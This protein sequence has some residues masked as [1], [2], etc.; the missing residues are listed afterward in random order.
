MVERMTRA[1]RASLEVIDK[2]AATGAHPAPLLFVHGGCHSAWYWDEGFLDYFAD[3]GFRAVALSLRGH[4]GSSSGK[5]LHRC[6][7][8]DFVDDVGTV[9]DTMDASVVLVGHS[10]GGFIVQ[11][12]L[13]NRQSTAAVLMAS[14]PPSGARGVSVRVIRRHPLVALRSN[15]SLRPEVVFKPP[16]TRESLFS[17][18]TPQEIVDACAER[19]ESES[20]RAMWFDSMFRLPNPLAVTTPMLVLGGAD[21]GTITN[22]DVRATARAYQ[23][24]AELFPGMG[25]NMMLEPGWPAVAGRI[26]SWLGER[27]L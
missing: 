7:M 17:R 10:V 2:G 3:R 25:H 12:Y 13:E 15:L 21:D 23:T 14:L 4:G 19:V 5:S 1:R 20:L 16:L 9:A 18:N 6:S 22:D 27:G 24:E 8:A 26:E 11:R